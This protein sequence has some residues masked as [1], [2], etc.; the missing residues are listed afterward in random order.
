MSP[1]QTQPSSQLQQAITDHFG[2][3]DQ[4]KE[5]FVTV[6]SNHFGSGWAW[7]ID[8]G[9]TLEIVSTPNQENPLMSGKK[10]LLGI[11]VREHA[12]YLKY[13]NRRVEYLNAWWT[14]INRDTVSALYN[15]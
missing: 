12:Y 8:N 3:I 15:S 9:T 2:S 11:D 1:S 7:L 6:A 5:Q 13:Q 14:V 4:L 10:V